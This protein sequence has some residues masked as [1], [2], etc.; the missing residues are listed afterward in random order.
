MT[1]PLKSTMFARG[2]ELLEKFCNANN[3][4]MPAIKKVASENW[5]FG[6]TCAYYRP[7]TI[8]ICESLCASASH[9]KPLWSWPGYVIDRTPYGVLAHELGH[10]ADCATGTQAGPYWSTYATDIRQAS[11]EERLTNYCPN[12]AEWF[13]E[14]FRLFITNPSLLAA[15]R[16]RTHDRLRKTW[17]PVV[18]DGWEKVLGDAP[19][20]IQDQAHRKVRGFVA[21]QTLLRV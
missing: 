21:G 3:L 14:M 5:R 10:H 9:G 13:A 7:T 16:P 17:V 2:V 11:R 15:L 18:A 20:W 4:V 8:T 1:R 6:R 12:D 19:E